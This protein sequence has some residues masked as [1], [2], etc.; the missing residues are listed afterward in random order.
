MTEQHAQR[1]VQDAFILFQSGR[2][3]EAENI[4]RDL[5]QRE[6]GN[7]AALHLL[8]FIAYQTNDAARAAELI[9]AA[10]EI[11]PYDAMAQNTYSAALVHLK[12]YGDAVQSA[13]RAV[14]LKPDFA[15]A[16]NNLGN[17]FTGLKQF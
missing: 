11:N 7:F 4:C 6:P 1:Q 5:L 13:E 12:R 3:S 17:A 14:A 16:Y 15:G 2:L 10:L 8:G 9:G